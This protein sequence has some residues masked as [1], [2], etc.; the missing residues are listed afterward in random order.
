MVKNKS[1]NFGNARYVRN[2][3]EKA[4]QCQADRVSQMKNVSDDQLV[5]ITLAD[6]KEGMKLTH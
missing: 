5:E 1:R 3:F 6:I 4:I 2:V